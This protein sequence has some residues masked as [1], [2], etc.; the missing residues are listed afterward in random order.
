MCLTLL[1]QA[2]MPLSFWWEA[3]STTTFLI[4]HLPTPTLSYLSPI[5]AFFHQKPN[6]QFLKTFGCAC[7]RHFFFLIDKKKCIQ[8]KEE[9][10]KT[11][12]SK[13]TGSIQK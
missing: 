11:V 6:F 4:N 8:L 3:F 10:Q 5:E 13:Y 9:A 2:A 12:P 7:Y 1:A